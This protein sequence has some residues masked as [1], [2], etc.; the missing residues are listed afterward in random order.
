MLKH[1]VAPIGVSVAQTR[2]FVT[3]TTSMFLESYYHIPYINKELEWDMGRLPQGRTRATLYVGS[4]LGI[5]RECRYPE[6]AWELLKQFISFPAQRMFLEQRIGGPVLRSVVE[7]EGASRWLPK[8]RDLF[9]AEMEAAR[10]IYWGNDSTRMKNLV[11]DSME[12]V[13]SGIETP[14]EACA[15]IRHRVGMAEG[16]IRF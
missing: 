15:E 12:M 3:G 14:E 4:H 8:H 16:Y 11:S 13:W 10:P 5:H 2:P 1:R 9:W 6:L 7:E